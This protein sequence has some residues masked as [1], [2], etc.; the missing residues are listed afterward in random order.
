MKFTDQKDFVYDTALFTRLDVQT[1][2]KIYRENVHR[3]GPQ[4]DGVPAPKFFE[5]DRAPDQYDS[6]WHSHRTD[7][8]QY[9][10]RSPIPVPAIN[11]FVK[12]DWKITRLGVTPGRRD[13]FFLS[14]LDLRELDY[15]PVRG[16]A[17]FWRGYRY[18]IM[19]AVVPPEAYW[20]QALHAQ[21]GVHRA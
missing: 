6:L 13:N 1:A 18:E 19:N 20:Q 4:K 3:H 12:P 10:A 21:P 9:T 11:Q 2:L 14:M 16:D 5:V 8:M 17:V 15:F 7:R